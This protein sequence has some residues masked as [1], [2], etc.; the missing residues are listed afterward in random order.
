VLIEGRWGESE[1]VGIAAD[2]FAELVA[3]VAEHVRIE[4][5]AYD[6]VLW[7]RVVADERYAA[8][9]RVA[10][11]RRHAEI[12]DVHLILRRGDDILLARRA[13]TGYADGLFNAPSV[14]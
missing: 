10:P 2:A 9:V 7:G 12:V 14:H 1:P 8:V 5:L 3:P 4:Q 13:N 11:P 6:S